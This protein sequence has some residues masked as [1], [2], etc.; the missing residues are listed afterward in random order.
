MD[1]SRSKALNSHTMELHGSRGLY[2]EEAP[3]RL[4]SAHSGT[5]SGQPLRDASVFARVHLSVV[6]GRCCQAAQAT[7]R[8]MTVN[9]GSRSIQ[10]AGTLGYPAEAFCFKLNPRRGWE[11][12]SSGREHAAA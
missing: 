12:V 4:A 10:T 1:R 9:R 2:G 7:G 6:R 8:S 5:V 3:D 11:F